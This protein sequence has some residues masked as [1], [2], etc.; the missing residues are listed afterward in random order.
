MIDQLQFAGRDPPTVLTTGYIESPIGDKCTDMLIVCHTS[1]LY[2]DINEPRGSRG[3]NVLPFP[4]TEPA[5]PRVPSKR[6]SSRR[7]KEIE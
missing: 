4:R 7:A 2:Y 3:P 1:H 6:E 5:K